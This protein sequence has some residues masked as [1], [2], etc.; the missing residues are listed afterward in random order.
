MPATTE[1]G[2]ELPAAAARSAGCAVKVGTVSLTRSDA[3]LLVAV[4][5]LSFTTQRNSSS[6]MLAEVVIVRVGVVEPL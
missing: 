1:K 4:P 5:V 3:A 2:T 6:F